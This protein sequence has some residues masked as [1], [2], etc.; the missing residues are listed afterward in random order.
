VEFKLACLVCQALCGQRQPTILTCARCHIRTTALETEALALSAHEFETV[1]RAAYGHLTS[2]TN[3]L[4]RCWRSICFD[5]AT[6]LCDILH[7]V[8]KNKQFLAPLCQKL[9]DLQL[10][11]IISH[12]NENQAKPTNILH[13]CMYKYKDD[14]QCALSLVRVHDLWRQSKWNQKDKGFVE[15]VVFKSGVKR[16][17]SGRWWGERWGCDLRPT[18]N[19]LFVSAENENAL[20]IK[21][22]FQPETETKLK[23][24][25]HLRPKTK[26]KTKLV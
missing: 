11:T 8:S 20:K 5:N 17:T 26:T 25:D 3:I 1:C 7:R 2:A 14:H 23:I 15:Q 19:D 24:W 16:Q 18:V 9:W 13:T 4:R 10:P 12:F 21:Y 22:H 6:A